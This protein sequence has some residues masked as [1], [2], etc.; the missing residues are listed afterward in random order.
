MPPTTTPTFVTPVRFTA[1]ALA[2]SVPNKAEVGGDGG[3]AVNVGDKIIGLIKSDS[4]DV[5]G[6][7]CAVNAGHNDIIRVIKRGGYEDFGSDVI[8]LVLLTLAVMIPSDLLS[9]RIW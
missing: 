3:I 9:A 6:Q 4:E 1:T 2:V 7:L 8:G 5:I